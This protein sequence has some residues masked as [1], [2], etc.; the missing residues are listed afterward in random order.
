MSQH[1]LGKVVQGQVALNGLTGFERRCI[2]AFPSDAAMN[3][4]DVLLALQ[5]NALGEKERATAMVCEVL[6]ARPHSLAASKK[7]AAPPRRP[8]TAHTTPDF[9]PSIKSAPSNARLARPPHSH[10]THQTAPAPP[11]APPNLPPVTARGA[12]GPDLGS[13]ASGRR[14]GGFARPDITR[15]AGGAMDRLVVVDGAPS[16]PCHSR[17]PAQHAQPHHRVLPRHSR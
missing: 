2:D 6:E 8:A 10:S 9:H 17:L 14:W 12:F 11:A 7:S 15:L 3:R 16:V 4:I 1:A 13:S 5:L